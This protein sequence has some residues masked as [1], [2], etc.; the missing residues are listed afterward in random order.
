MLTGPR[1]QQVGD[2]IQRARRDHQATRT[3]QLAGA[4]GVVIATGALKLVGD[5]LA[6]GAPRRVSIL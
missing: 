3:G 2:Q 1:G 6:G 5:L 4:D